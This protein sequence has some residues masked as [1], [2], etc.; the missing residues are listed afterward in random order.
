M[1]CITLYVNIFFVIFRAQDH[2]ICAYICV[3]IILNGYLITIHYFLFLF[4]FY[5][6][7]LKTN[8]FSKKYEEL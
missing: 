4:N 5:K 8:I 1:Q 7:Y 2:Y 6:V 3:R